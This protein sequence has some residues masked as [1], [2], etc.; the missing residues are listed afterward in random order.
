VSQLVALAEHVETLPHDLNAPLR[1]DEKR[2]V[3]TAL[4]GLRMLSADQLQ[5]A[6]PDEV[7]ESLSLV[8]RQLSLLGKLLTRKYL[9][10]SGTPRQITSDVELLQ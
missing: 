1:T 8:D 4:H 5:E 2:V 10:H 3:M 9:L 7:V 6:A